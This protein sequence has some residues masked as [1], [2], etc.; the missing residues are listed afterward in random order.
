MLSREEMLARMLGSDPDANGQF[1]V[2]VLTTGIYCLPTCRPSRKPKP[3]NVT[4]YAT[5]EEA[6][7]AGFR[8]C[9]LCKPDDFY[10]GQHAEEA[11]TEELV[12]RVGREPGRF[13]GVGEMAAA[14][15]VSTSKLH[16]LCRAHY[17]TTPAHL[18]ARA[19]IARAR[20]ELLAGER[21]VAAIAYDVGFASLSAFNENFRKFTAMAPLDYRQL[22]AGEPFVLRLPTGYPLDRILRYL[23]RGKQSLTTRVEGT[24]YT[25]VFRAEREAGPPATALVR[26]TFAPGMARCEIVRKRGLDPVALGRIQE[27]LYRALGLAEDPARFE[28]RIARSA[29]LAPLILGQCGLRVPLIAD[30]FDALAWAIIGQQINLAFAFTLRRRLIERVGC[31]F[32]NCL[33]APPDAAA[34]AALEPGELVILGFSRSKA[35]Y[36]IGIARAVQTGQ[37]PLADLAKASATRIE[38]TLL[39]QRGIGPWSA[40]Y[41]LMRHYGFGDCVP[42]GDAVL[43]AALQRFFALDARP[44]P[45][46]TIAL[47]APF[48][49][50]RSLATFHFW[51]RQHAAA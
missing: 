3:E 4:F 45:R 33:Y 43:A 15:G 6:R 38:R 20:L 29:D 30:P 44:G 13:A 1:V 37:F 27:Q 11:L 24:T 10:S 26:V 46:E 23:G 5:P 9:K 19:R 17:Q 18:L 7:A 51:Q 48:S 28:A 40:C 25:E 42:V 39:A 32:A 47:M 49:P 2:A 34:V 50:S 22:R 12:A 31:P 14:A 21:Q 8:P 41:L 36:L 35:E 16:D